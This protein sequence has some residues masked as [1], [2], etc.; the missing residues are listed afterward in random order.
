MSRFL[1]WFRQRTVAVN[2]AYISHPECLA[3]EMDPGH[4]ECPE[5]IQAV[6]DQ[7]LAAG[8]FY[9]L[10]QYDAPL[11]TVEHLQRVHSLLYINELM[12]MVPTEGLVRLDPDTSM[13]PGSM[14]SALRAAGAGVLATELVLKGEVSNAFCNVR[15]PGHH[16][17]RARA[18]GFCFFNNIAVA[19]A[20]A[21]EAFGLRRVAILDFDV[22]FGNG[23]EQIFYDDDRVMICSTFEDNL[24]P[25]V[26]YASTERLVNVPLA[27]GTRGYDFREAVSMFWLPSL[28][29]FAPEMIFISAGFDGHAEDD[30]AHFRLN[31]RDYAWVTEQILAI[32]DRYCQGRVVSM[33]EGG[34]ALH[35]LGRSVAEHVRAL[36][37][38]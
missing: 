37:R 36:M 1:Q 22:H 8:L 32:A 38:L 17:E 26:P 27:A 6:Q 5:R 35:A 9:H 31:Q 13:G 15:P 25:F 21:M 20:H 7:L 11:A 29:R 18:M 12:N 3:H 14:R 28:E 10:R 30:L 16:A 4:P 33:L 23:T 34:Y 2:T 24:Y 19:A